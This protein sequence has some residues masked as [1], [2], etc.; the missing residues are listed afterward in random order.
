MHPETRSI[1]FVCATLMLGGI[2]AAQDPRFSVLGEASG[3][4][5]GRTIAG[6]HDV[7]GDGR[8]DWIAGARG[9]QSSSFPGKAYVYSGNGALL[10]T[11][12]GQQ[13]GDEL[14]AAVALSPDLDGD[15]IGEVL[16]GSRY[17]NGVAGN[18]TGRLT[19][20]RGGTWTPLVILEGTLPGENFGASV[21]V[22]GDQNGDGKADFAVGVP[23]LVNG[24]SGR[25]EIRSGATFQTLVTYTGTQ[26]A[27]WFGYSVAPAGDLNS[28]G[29]PDIAVASVAYD[30]PAGV[31]AGR[32]SVFRGGIAPLTTRLIL[33]EGEGAGDRLGISMASVGD[34][35][36]D[37]I[38]DLVFGASRFDLPGT[39]TNDNRGRAY[40]YSGANGTLLRTWTGEASKDWFGIG[41]SNGGDVD[42]DGIDE[43]LIGACQ[44][45]KGGAGRAYLI[46]GVT[47]QVLHVLRGEHASG[48]P[49]NGDAYGFAVSTL[50]DLDLDGASE[51]VV[52]AYGVDG[53]G[54]P[55]TGKLYVYSSAVVYFGVGLPAPQH[56]PLRAQ[57]WPTIGTT[58]DVNVAGAVPFMPSLLGVAATRV[59]SQLW[60]GTMYLDFATVTFAPFNMDASGSYTFSVPIPNDVQ[61][62]N[63]RGVMQVV[64]YDVTQPAF[65][66]WSNGL[67]LTLVP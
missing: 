23:C 2:L 9:S 38:P 44:T 31:D 21:A 8:L 40:L 19:I 53:F 65:A 22:V 50:G 63:L 15:G 25:V 49:G 32:I 12:I 51:F 54:G 62:I 55:N 47:G 35:N 30:G 45:D 28:D 5:L 64:S 16:V 11:F 27:E 17:A 24:T 29:V 37:L 13:A 41:V 18:D 46:N 14:G 20:Y 39:P 59:D 4:E 36:A 66:G 26:A 56:L 7:N 33:V 1:R 67:Q 3:N 10:H 61:L 6:G 34:M 60:G 43:I 52:G 58:F 48:I 57:T 42:G